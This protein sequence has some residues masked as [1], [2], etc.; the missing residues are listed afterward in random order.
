V[1]EI[2]DSA[3]SSTQTGF[4]A[5]V[6]ASASPAAAP[7]ESDPSISRNLGDGSSPSTQS[8]ETP[9]SVSNSFVPSNAKR[10]AK[11]IVRG[12]TLAVLGGFLVTFV[13]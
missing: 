2:G 3:P 13:V 5:D 12:A 10:G 4:H 7:F 11:D 6:Q 8:A 9:E 1:Q